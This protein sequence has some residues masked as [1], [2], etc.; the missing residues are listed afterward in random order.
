MNTTVG[1]AEHIE[2]NQPRAQMQT[3]N[4]AAKFPTLTE[5]STI[6]IL[7]TH[8]YLV[9][10]TSL[11]NDVEKTL[12]AE[13]N[14]PG[15]I[16]AHNDG[17][18]GMLSRRKFFEMLGTRYG[19]AVFYKRPIQIMVKQAVSPTILPCSS[20]IH[21][22]VNQAL[23][24][25]SNFVYE[26]ILVEYANGEYRLLD[27]YTLLLAQSQQFA[28]LQTELTEVN[29]ELEG[30]VHRRTAA[31]QEANAHL[32][33]E[34]KERKLAEENLQIR[35]RYEQALSQSAD[36]LLSALDNPDVI[37]ETLDYLL[38]AT[39]VSRVFMGLNVY[40][41]ELGDCLQLNHQVFAIDAE[42]IPDSLSLFPHKYLG[43]WAAIL[44]RG[45]SLVGHL[46]EAEGTAKQLLIMLDIKSVLL[47]PISK[48][49]E[50]LGVI[51]LDETAVK[52]I[53]KEDD[54]QL[55]QT[56]ARMLSAYI[57]RQRKREALAQARDTAVK[58]S[59]FKS[60]LVA[61]VSH[62]LRTPLGAIK[63]YAQLMQMGS[64]GKLSPK[65]DEPLELIISSTNYLTLLVNELLD[66]AKLESQ[67]LI[68]QA[69]PFEPTRMVRDV[70]LRMRVLAEYKGLKFN[71]VIDPTLPKELIGDVTRLQQILTNL[72]GNAIKF[73]E[74][75]FVNTNI[76]KLGTDQWSL[77][78]V[79]SGPGIPQKAQATIFEPFG[80]VDGSATREHS[81]TGLGL[82]IS[83]QLVELMGGTISLQSEVGQ[84]STFT[85]TL[86]L[87]PT[88]KLN[89]ENATVYGAI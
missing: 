46:D 64:Y 66:Q 63:G 56:V 17:I 34:I 76:K 74:S 72:L 31:L 38:S 8:L 51:A 71:I 26:P 22:A 88:E 68:L 45:K 32:Y 87:S 79:D 6:S 15:V 1:L 2:Q 20:S 81:G 80:Q 36:S 67:K 75:G 78:V 41:E 48:R 7:P 33:E 85:V 60:E 9:D 14:L 73:T 82:S 10:E 40:D 37:P 24:R 43:E 69:N 19:V 83:K 59:Q 18:L 11:V 70:E 25:E 58:A 23:G 50:W 28:A 54:I 35:V 84:G 16:V 30:R 47:L 5:N 62:E 89:N 65:Q 4:I 61:K 39:G 49:D 42:P 21:A 86:P 44:Q 13:P 57:D 52:R 12:R 77:Q 53:W 55:M 27:I 3:T 29:T